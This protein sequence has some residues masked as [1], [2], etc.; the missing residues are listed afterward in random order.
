MATKER[1]DAHLLYSC[2]QRTWHQHI[3]SCPE[4]FWEFLGCWNT[5]RSKEWNVFALA[6]GL[7]CCSALW[8][9]VL[10]VF[11]FPVQVECWVSWPAAVVFQL[12]VH[13][14]RICTRDTL[15]VA[16]KSPK[17]VNKGEWAA[18]FSSTNKDKSCGWPPASLPLTLAI[19][20][21]HSNDQ[22]PLTSASP[23]A[24]LDY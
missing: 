20:K 9:W 21:G 2:W 4:C 15:G 7:R 22:P 16:K 5:R 10:S 23:A 1:L 12:S 17:Q 11:I 6:C 8:A 24:C 14:R 18:A 13:T 3:P 19:P